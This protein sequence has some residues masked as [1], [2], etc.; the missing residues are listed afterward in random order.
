MNLPP[1][2]LRQ[3]YELAQELPAQA[4]QPL[5]S[6]IANSPAGHWSQTL[7]Q[8]QGAIAH[9][10]YR[11]KVGNFVDAWRAS[12]PEAEPAGVALALETAIYCVEATRRSQTLEL[13]WTGPQSDTALRRTDQA[14]LQ[15]IESARSELLIV[16]FAV[17]SIPD[18]RAALVRASKRG[19]QLTIIIESPKESDGKIAYDG[20]IALGKAVARRAHI[21]RWPLEKRKTLPD[22]KHGALHVKCAI[23]DGH[24]LLVSSA[25]LTE[26][27]LTLNMEMGLLVTGGRIPKQ[28][29]QHFRRLIEQGTLLETER[30]PA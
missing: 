21:F 13:V 26:Y 25:N 19:V 23:A 28:V 7:R 1:E 4:I 11:E 12:A 17:Y 29:A 2:L 10:Y 5:V 20:L 8:A 9:A 6:S 16:S 27:A 14:L 22:G 24:V 15:L 30:E 18:I 3:V